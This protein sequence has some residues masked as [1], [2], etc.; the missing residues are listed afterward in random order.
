VRL[1]LSKRKRAKSRAPLTPVYAWFS[2]GFD[3]RNLKD[4]ERCSTRW[5]RDPTPASL[6]IRNRRIVVF[7]LFVAPSGL[8]L[9]PIV[10]A[11]PAV[12]SNTVRSK[13]TPSSAD[14]PVAG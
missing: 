2:E 7:R 14:G 5:S 13:V 11:N 9:A 4:R 6:G 3:L 12:R 1:W 10:A 8:G